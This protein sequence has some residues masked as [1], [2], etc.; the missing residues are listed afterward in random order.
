MK[1]GP[2][3]KPIGV[4]KSQGTFRGD[5]HG[6]CPEIEPNKPKCPNWLGGG[7]KKHWPEICQLLFDHGII[8]KVDKVSLSLLVDSLADWIETTKLCIALDRPFYLA[9][10]GNIMKHPVIDMKDK[11]WNR[12]LKAAREFGMTPA[13]LRGVTAKPKKDKPKGKD[14]GRFFIKG[15]G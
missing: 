15:T 4:L 14:K 1:R 8:S 10:S 3:E 2:K 5:R 12:V 6:D 13:S 7:A 11:A 9:A